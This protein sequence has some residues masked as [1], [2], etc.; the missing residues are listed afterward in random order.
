M[1]RPRSPYVGYVRPLYAFGARIALA[2]TLAFL[3]CACGGRTPE[4]SSLYVDVPE[5]SVD[6]LTTTTTSGATE[7]LAQQ[8]RQTAED[9]GPSAPPSV[10]PAKFDEVEQI[11][12][13]YLQLRANSI[14]RTDQ[15]EVLDRVATPAA[16]QQVAEALAYNDDRWDQAKLSAIDSLYLYSNVEEILQLD[17][18]TVLVVDC[19]ERHEI[20]A[21]NQHL[22]YFETN[23][24]RIIV[25][26]GEMFVDSFTTVHNGY[27]EVDN[28]LGCAPIGFRER[29]EAASAQVWTD[30]A[31]WGRNSADRSDETLSQQIGEPLRSRVLDAALAGGEIREHVE[32]T[33][34]TATGLDTL[35]RIGADPITES[36][37]QDLQPGAEQALRFHVLIDPDP[38][39]NPLDQVLSIDFL[40]NGC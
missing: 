21:I 35:G 20:N 8:R 34:F 33:Q 39:Q 13:E 5:T 10:A 32:N 9:S 30:L 6:G 2:I 22:T 17:D 16:R 27:L 18:N 1:P 28:P 15:I 7:D 26:D 24:A 37:V 14:D 12:N 23:E 31:A 36:L 4:T 38:S 11:Y 19:T 29:A 25:K 3:L 40:G